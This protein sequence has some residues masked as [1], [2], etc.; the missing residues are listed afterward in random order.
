MLT[1]PAS[2]CYRLV[3]SDSGEARAIKSSKVE[4]LQRRRTQ[5]WRVCS[6]LLS[7]AKSALSSKPSRWY[8]AL[9]KGL[10]FETPRMRHEERIE[11]RNRGQRLFGNG[12]I[13]E[14]SCC[15]WTFSWDC[16]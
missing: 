8:E 7:S 1:S 4:M 14:M 11:K 5:H 10:L 6:I 3:G 15:R 2:G 9:R 12:I 13:D 16:E